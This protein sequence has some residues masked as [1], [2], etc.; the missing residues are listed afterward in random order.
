MPKRIRLSY[1]KF[2]TIEVH[3]M[4][5]T[6]TENDARCAIQTFLDFYIKK[7]VTFLKI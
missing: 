7:S 5:V 6:V 2:C 3:C 1:M 4:Y